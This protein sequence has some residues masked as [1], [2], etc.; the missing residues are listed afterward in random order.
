MKTKEEILSDNGVRLS[1]Q[2]YE[3]KVLVSMQEYSDQ[4]TKPLIDEI[5][6]LE[7]QFEQSDK[8]YSD[9]L[10]K[11]DDF[12][13]KWENSENE[14][15]E[16]RKAL[17]SE[18]NDAG[19]IQEIKKVLYESAKKTEIPSGGFEINIQFEEQAKALINQFKITR[20]NK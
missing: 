16:L 12:K 6:T 9:L 4:N 14:I 11:K 2:G 17:K 1:T 7:S 18:A 13:L 5:T 8:M 3:N 10:A 15:A 19:L 20:N